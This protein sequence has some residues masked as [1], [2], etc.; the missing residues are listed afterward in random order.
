MMTY[1][2]FL[3]PTGKLCLRLRNNRKK[4]ELNLLEQ[5]TP[6][7]FEQVMQNQ[8]KKNQK[9]RLAQKISYTTKILTEISNYLKDD[10]RV[11]LDVFSIRGLVEERLGLGERGQKGEFVL[12]FEKFI[13]SKTNIGTKKLYQHT[14]DRIQKLTPEAELLKFSQI[15]IGWL[16]DF[17]AKCALTA[18]KN[19]RNIHLRNI[20][21]V[22]NYALM[23]DLDIP[24]PFRR[25]KIHSEKT[26]KRNLKVDD[27]RQLFN[28]PV[29][30]YAEI[31]R[32]MFK[33]IFMLIGINV[34]DLY[35]LKKITNG[36][37]EYRRA[38][39]GTLYSIKVEPEAMEIIEKY[40]GNNALLLLAD[41]WDDRANFLH[42]CNKALQRIGCERIG[43][44]GKKVNGLWPEISTYWARHSWS[45]IARSIGIS[46]DDIALALGHS[47]GHDVTDIYIEDD[48][49]KI[50]IA[51]R[52]VLDWVLYGK[53]P[54]SSEPI[55]LSYWPQL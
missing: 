15:T 23:H 28:F 25:F 39:T 20:R 13:E 40:K 3:N 50:D 54:G 14:L 37:I 34:S 29:E 8:N 38:K 27:L 52:K 12:W 22:F 9:G 30:P 35:N 11:G 10:G 33:L 49:E 31:Y 2:F 7:E 32:D 47:S 1:K 36:R 16:E 21:A 46:K 42:Q 41:R 17:E 26:R 48:Y 51:N 4:T 18:S 5:T 19:A 44:G 55:N 45:T 24:Y 43:R 53:L 6:E